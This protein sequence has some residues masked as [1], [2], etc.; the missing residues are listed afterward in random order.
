MEGQSEFLKWAD[1]Q[2]SVH[3]RRLP[4]YRVVIS[5]R[6]ASPTQVVT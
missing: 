1:S 5:T 4:P 2:A 6:T 3:I